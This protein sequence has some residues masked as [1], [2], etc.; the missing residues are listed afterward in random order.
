M[1]TIFRKQESC[2][3]T[4]EMEMDVLR[5]QYSQLPEKTVM[6]LFNISCI[7]ADYG[8]YLYIAELIP[9]FSKIY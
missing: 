9:R 7:K 1:E 6:G 2:G 4:E 8:Y 5:G 3:R